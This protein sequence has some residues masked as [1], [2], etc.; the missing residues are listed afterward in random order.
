MNHYGDLTQEEV[1]AILY[2]KSAPGS[3]LAAASGADYTHKSSG[4]QV[5]SSIDWRTLGAVNPPKDQGVC[6][7][8]W[9]F[10]TTG[11]IEGAWFVKTGNLVSLSEQQIVDCA[12]YA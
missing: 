6:G 7:S 10:G 5:P 11:A 2:P 12:W 8:C 3:R 9:T 1:R 4:R